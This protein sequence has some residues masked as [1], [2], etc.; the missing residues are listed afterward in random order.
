[1][2]FNKNVPSESEK[3]WIA[4][5][6]GEPDVSDFADL[7]EKEKDDLTSVWEKAGTNYSYSAANPG[8]GWSALQNQIKNS[9]NSHKI[10]IFRNPV[11][12]YAAMVVLVAGIGFLAY[13]TMKTP[14]TVEDIPIRMLTAQTE[15]HPMTFTTVIL[16]DGSI[17]KLNANTKMDYPERFARDVR[18]VR[19][20]GE[21][22]FEV[23]QIGRAHV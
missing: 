15:T 9:E 23:T 21:A 20:S 7:G 2:H 11:L 8:K 3:R 19:L 14:Q 6:N 13:Q 22:F 16:P 10:T 4:Y 5:L 1:M 17:V 18:K 12:K